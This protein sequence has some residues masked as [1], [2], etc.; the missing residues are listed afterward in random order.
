MGVCLSCLG[1]GRRDNHDVSNAR[2]AIAV[3]R[4]QRYTDFFQNSP[5]RRDS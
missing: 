5:N 2:H 1:Y 4:V 3:A